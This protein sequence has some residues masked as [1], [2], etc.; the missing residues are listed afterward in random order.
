LVVGWG[1]HFIEGF[2][3]TLRFDLIVAIGLDQFIRRGWIVM[4]FECFIKV[5]KLLAR[6]VAHRFGF[7]GAIT[8]LLYLTL[9]L[10]SLFVIGLLV[11]A[12]FV[13]CHPTH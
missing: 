5:T 6:V 7:I 8:C 10:A 2:P 4:G 3:P 9:S 11:S 12:L 13:I 1:K